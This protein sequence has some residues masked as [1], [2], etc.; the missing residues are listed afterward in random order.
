MDSETQ[1]QQALDYLYSFIDHSLTRNLRN[2]PENFNLDRMR[3]LMSLMGDPQNTYKIVHVAGTKGKGSTSAF[4]AS[5][6]HAAGYNVGFYTSPH[7]HDYCERIQVN[8]TKLT[9]KNFVALLEQIRPYIAMVEGITTFELTTAIAFLYFAGQKVDY[10]VVEVGLGGR[11]DATNIVDPVVSV[12]TSL[13]LDHV[14]VLGDTLAQISFEKAGIIKPGKP[15]VISPQKEEAKRV[16]DRIAE[17]RGSMILEVGQDYLYAAAAHN[18]DGQSFIVWSKDEQSAVS[19]YI[20][21]SGRDEWIPKRFHIPLLGFHQVQNA[22]TAYAALQVLIDC[23]AKISDEDISI[24]L[25]NVSWPGRF[26]IIS[27]KPLMVVDSA[28]NR[29]SALRLRLTVDDYFPGIPVTLIFGASEDKDI[30]GMLAELLPR[31]KVVVAT[32]S[33]H[34]RA[35]DPEIVVEYALKSG[36]RGYVTNTIEEAIDKA[37]ELSGSESLILAAGSL[38]VAAAVRE[39]WLTHLKEMIL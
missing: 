31:V 21:S 1:Y 19:R 32:K 12:I 6:L 17:E 11:L 3:R 23:G 33:E 34:P 4:I 36:K 24:G 30:E 35:L 26:E 20:E 10:A 38:F 9:H 18:L 39:V 13:S 22:A 27:K 7:L 15:V 14:N 8:R 5:V 29:E 25:S 28:H 37:I 16:L 2:S